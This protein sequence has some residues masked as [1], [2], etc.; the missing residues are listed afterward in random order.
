MCQ[1]SIK[2]WVNQAQ[3]QAE[4]V[5]DMNQV[6][7]QDKVLSEITLRFLEMVTLESL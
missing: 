7:K 3:L 4:L 2:Q 6:L 1:I 5:C